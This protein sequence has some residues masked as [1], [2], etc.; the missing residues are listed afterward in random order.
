MATIGYAHTLEDMRRQ[1]NPDGSIDSILEILAESNPILADCPFIEGDLPIGNKTTVRA[2]LP[3]PSIRRINRG[4]ASTKGTARQIIDVCMN[5][6]D[7]STIDTEL[8]TGKPNPQQYRASE[9]DAHVEGM[10][11]YVARQMVYGDLDADPDTFNGFDVRYKTLAG[12][13]GTPG[14]QVISAGTAGS[15]TNTTM[16]IVDWGDRRVTGIYPK[17]TVAGLKTRDLGEFD[18]YDADGNPYRA[19]GT[20]YN[21]KVGLA[22]HNVRCVAAI[23]NIDVSKLSTLTDAQQRQLMDKFIFAK[24]RLWLPKAPVVYCSDS[25]YSFLETYLLNK[26]NV[27]VTRQD[28]EN[29]PP[30]LRFA[31]MP[32][33]K[34]D[35]I[36]ETEA[37]VTE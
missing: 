36:S 8:L 18:A 3:S 28:R 10:G 27:H 16:W 20:L 5:L 34:C 14:Y 17:N 30:L 19:V 25:V 11:Q 2:S 33:R 37:A 22:V 31:G 32:V 23:R 35:C 13:K 26:A 15:N 1:M 9:D 24:N 21:W 29:E 12:G 7:R 4:T 6:E